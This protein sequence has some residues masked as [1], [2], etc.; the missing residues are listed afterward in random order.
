MLDPTVKELAQGPNYAIVSTHMPDGSIQSAPLWVDADDEHLLINT[1]VHRQRYRN[2][3]RDPR[4]TVL[5]LQEGTWY[6]HAEVR[7][8]VVGEVRGPEA[9]AHIDALT[10]RY[11]GVDDY[12]NAIESERVILKVAPDRQRLFPPT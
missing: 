9:R 12:P 5:V 10:K 8:Q 1:E 6:R 7:G 2:L 4:V 11:M 3:Q